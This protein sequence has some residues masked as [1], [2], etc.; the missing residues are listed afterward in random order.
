MRGDRQAESVKSQNTT[1]RKTDIELNR[2]AIEKVLAAKFNPDLLE[3]REDRGL[4]SPMGP[5]IAS[6]TDASAERDLDHQVSQLSRTGRRDGRGCRIH[7]RS[8]LRAEVPGQ[9]IAAVTV[10]GEPSGA[11]SNDSEAA[12]FYLDSGVES[13]PSA[14]SAI[15]AVAIVRRPKIAF[16]LISHAPA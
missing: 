7:G 1:C 10:L 2:Y 12:S 11:S 13:A 3:S 9:G 16:T 5:L 8:T 15:V 14:S 4:S 6:R